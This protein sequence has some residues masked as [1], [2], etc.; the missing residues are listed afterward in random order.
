MIKRIL[1]HLNTAILLFNRN[2]NL[3]YVNTAGEI[4]LADSS[5]H[6]LGISA[7]DLFKFSDPVLLINLQQCL[8]MSEPLVDRELLLDRMGHGVTIN[9]S[10]T[11]LTVDDRVNEILVEMQRG[12]TI[13]N[14]TGA[15]T[16]AERPV[17]YCVVTRSEI[18]QLKA[19]VHEIDPKAF[20]VVGAAH[21]ALGEG[22]QPFKKS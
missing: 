1:D 6:L 15:Y 5:R 21:E 12:V 16:G 22:F 17:L 4:L 7:A 9:L 3:V 13:L 10:A 8:T 18:Q 19:I 11:P 20:M 14:G 2:L